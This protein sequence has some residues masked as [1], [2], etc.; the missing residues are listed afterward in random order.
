MKRVNKCN[1]NVA[2]KNYSK[3]CIYIKVFKF[4]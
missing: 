4:S 1:G 3:P 2:E